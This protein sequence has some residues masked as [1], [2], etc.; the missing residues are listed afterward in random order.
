V[1]KAIF[2]IV[3]IYCII[4]AEMVMLSDLIV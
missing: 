3:V 4:L 2:V 1:L